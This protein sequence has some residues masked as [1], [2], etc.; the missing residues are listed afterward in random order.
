M[1][2]FYGGIDRSC[3]ISPFASI[4]N[5]DHVF[6]GKGA[7]INRNAIVWAHLV[8]GSNLQLN[9]GACIY[10]NVEIGNNVLIAPNV[11]IAGGN[12]GYLRNGIPM[13][14]QSDNSLGIRIGDDV[15]IGA[16]SVILDGVEL[17]EG[18]VIAAGS[19]VNNSVE[20]YSIVAGV[21]ARK[22]KERPC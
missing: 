1:H 8:A 18:A 6:F 16:N 15:W 10:G 14:F 22:I 19:V 4:R 21:P 9:P 20:P 7:I 3:F 5:H 17:G 11:V 12:H 2:S 13:C